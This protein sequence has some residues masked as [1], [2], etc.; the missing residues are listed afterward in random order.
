MS[1]PAH[2]VATADDVSLVDRL[3]SGR[4][5][6]AVL[7]VGKD[8]L[9]AGVVTRTD[10]LEIARARVKLVG[11][12]ATLELP[13][14]AVG[15]I[16]T[17]E[18]ITIGPETSV[19]D[20]AR[21]LVE[22]HI[23]RVFV[24]DAKHIKGVFSTTDAIRAVMDARI[25]TPISAYMTSPALSTQ[26]TDPISQAIEALSQAGVAGVVVLDVD[27]AIGLFTQVEALEARDLPTTTPVEEVMT[28][29]M[30]CLPADTPMFRAAG[31]TFSTWAR[32]V[33]ATDHHHVRGILTGLDFA[34]ACAGLHDPER[35]VAAA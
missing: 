30:V 23:H 34:R 22:R 10:L 20:A 4:H 24:G 31:F 29:S 13:E 17:R 9:P 11:S 21:L 15:D 3:L 5:M 18:V 6:S 35:G 16:M 27:R 19:A 25:E 1:S 28:Q 2:T 7:V 33:L 8:G 14:I 26:A 12:K 32:R